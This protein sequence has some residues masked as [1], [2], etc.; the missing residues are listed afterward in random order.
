M[1][2]RSLLALSVLALAS[3]GSVGVVGDDFGG[4]PRPRRAFPAQTLEGIVYARA[5]FADHV[6]EF[7][8][9]LIE[10]ASVVPIRLSMQVQGPG[11][12]VAQIVLQPSQM[13]LRLVLSDGA[14]LLPVEIDDV[15]ESL[16][17]EVAAKVR[18]ASFRG[19]LLRGTPT[20]GYVFFGIKP[21]TEFAMSG[22]IIKHASRGVL[23]S[24]DVADALLAFKIAVG[25]DDT[26][27]PF[28][29]GIER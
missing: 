16:D 25:S 1:T 10:E 28:Y 26:K 18:A 3:C 14:V 11:A 22:R 2:L 4:P 20:E 21:S 27:S 13:G 23:R 19:G 5:R 17:E 24:L 15:V 7:G 9:D 29:V 6:A 8:E 12:D